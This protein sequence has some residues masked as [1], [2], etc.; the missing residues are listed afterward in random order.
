[1]PKSLK[2]E[3][4]IENAKAARALGRALVIAEELA[5]DLTYR[6]DVRELRRA[7]YAAR[8]LKLK[9]KR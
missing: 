9:R 2:L 8:R 7:R 3:I 1:M 6:E 5:E 4:T